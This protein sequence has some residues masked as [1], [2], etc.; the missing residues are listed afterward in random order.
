MK[1]K[2]LIKDLEYFYLQDQDAEVLAY[3]YDKETKTEYECDFTV[4]GDVVPMLDLTDI[5]NKYKTN[6]R[7]FGKV[8][9]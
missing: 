5:K 3:L 1:V 7:D 9:E 6:L 8:E 2:D 4:E